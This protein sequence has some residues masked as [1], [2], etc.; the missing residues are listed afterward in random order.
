MIQ[1]FN[2]LIQNHN[3]VNEPDPKSNKL[4]KNDIL[5]RLEETLKVSE[6]TQVIKFEAMLFTL[7]SVQHRM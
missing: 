2:C 4:N 6:I 7:Q 3:S 1:M 5:K